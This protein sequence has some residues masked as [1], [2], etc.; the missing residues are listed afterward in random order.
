[1]DH[2]PVVPKS[3]EICIDAQVAEAML[4]RNLSTNEDIAAL[5]D[6]EGV[7]ED[8]RRSGHALSCLAGQ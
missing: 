2:L 5:S 7:R 3:L 6:G 4:Q 1:M 8:G